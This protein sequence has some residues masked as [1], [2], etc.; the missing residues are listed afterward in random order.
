M[1]GGI[2]LLS[3]TLAK[4][5]PIVRTIREYKKEYIRKDIIAALTVAVVSIPQSM[6]Y[7]LI[8]GVNP[9]YG[10]YTAIVSAIIGSAF[11][12][13]KYLVTG[14]TNA[15]CLLIAVSMR[16]YMGLDSA[17]QMLFLMTFVVGVLQIIFGIIKL[18]KVINFVSHTVIVGFTAGAGVLIAIEQLNTLLSISIK[19][20]S[21]MSTTENLY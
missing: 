16:N 14:P 13:S 12:S 11:G 17:Y 15:I 4:Y 7:A 10:L 9:V 2:R 6:A 20:S 8:A 19:N 21:Q 5:I 1:K 18:G 3:S